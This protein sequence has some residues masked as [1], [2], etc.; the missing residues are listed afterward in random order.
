MGEGI[1][2]YKLSGVE[3]ISHGDVMYHV[4]EYSQYYC[5]AHLKVAKIINLKSF[6]HKEGKILVQ[7][8][9]ADVN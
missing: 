7:R 6:H 1:K 9:V 3:Y 4:V 8:M 2:R 5:V